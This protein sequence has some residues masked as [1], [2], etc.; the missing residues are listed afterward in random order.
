ML[1]SFKDWY[2]QLG[3][4]SKQR[5][6][7]GGV[8]GIGGVILSGLIFAIDSADE[9][10]R[11]ASIEPKEV[12]IQGAS[13]QIPPDAVWRAK[14]E[15][16]HNLNKQKIDSLE[17]TIKKLAEPKD[18]HLAVEELQKQITDLQEQVTTSKNPQQSSDIQ[19]NAPND[20]YNVDPIQQYPTSLKAPTNSHDVSSAEY[21]SGITK[22]VIELD[23]DIGKGRSTVDETIPAG[24]FARAVLIGGVDASTSVQSASD[25]R[26]ILL[27][28]VDKGTLP[29]KFK[30]D[31]KHCHVLGSSYGD[32]SSERVYIRLE[33]L[34]CTEELTGEISETQVSGYVA[35]EDGKSGV[36]GVL[37]DKAGEQVRNAF[38]GGF[39]GGMGEF[40]SS[41]IKSGGISTTPFGS[42]SQMNPLNKGQML[43]NGVGQGA[44]RAFEKFADFYM[45]R[46]EQLQPVLQVAAGRVVDI[47]FTQ[48]TKFGDT[49]AR[50]ALMRVRDQ[51]RQQR[52]QEVNY[53]N[54][55]DW[56]PE[57]GD[58]EE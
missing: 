48:G 33:K 40:L 47:V 10:S 21:S 52:V 7:R 23:K 35:G 46:A 22:V 57:G 19:N 25:P 15:A 55:Q 3:V 54:D 39:V 34:T 16:E 24:A 44:S 38:I 20:D 45:K 49:E 41:T 17:E 30:S 31:L 2:S 9:T 53:Q 51:K 8:I 56:L 26:P 43:Q 12:A 32:I 27:R 28:V 37:V 5:L 1:E 11:K 14:Y 36:R 18:D 29:R 13:S 6:L 58:N 50:N 42:V 4:I